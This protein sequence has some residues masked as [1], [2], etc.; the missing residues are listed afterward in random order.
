MLLLGIGFALNINQA[1]VSNQTNEVQEVGFDN[2]DLP[3][4]VNLG[5]DNH[6][7]PPVVNLGFD[8]H[9]LPPVV[10]L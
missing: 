8:N 3:P 2:H 7:L 1:D 10:N 5:F 9:D 6:D 4:V